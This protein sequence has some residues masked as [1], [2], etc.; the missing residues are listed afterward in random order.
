M[1][2]KAEIEY[3]NNAEY[4]IYNLAI[5]QLAN[6]ITELGYAIGNC[7]DLEDLG[8]D[9]NAYKL[10]EAMVDIATVFAGAVVGLKYIKPKESEVRDGET[11]M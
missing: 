3:V 7:N 6:V 11:V 9:M 5:E 2:E 1:S 10:E 4:R 8:Y